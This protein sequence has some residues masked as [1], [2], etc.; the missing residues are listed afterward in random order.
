MRK[1]ALT[2]VGMIVL[3]AA[4]IGGGLTLDSQWTPNG[5]LVAAVQRKDVAAVRKALR[6]GADPNAGIPIEVESLGLT[7][8]VWHLVSGDY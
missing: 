8:W 2:I 3:V 5:R 1:A 7:D 6:A 4:V